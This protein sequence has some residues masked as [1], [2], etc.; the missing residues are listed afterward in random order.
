[1]SEL[2]GKRALFLRTN[3][4]ECSDDAG[5]GYELSLNA[6]VT[7]MVCSKQTGFTFVL[8]WDDIVRLAVEAGIDNPDTEVLN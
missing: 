4:G 3:V 1:M 7:P 8:R 6:G 5:N 2:H